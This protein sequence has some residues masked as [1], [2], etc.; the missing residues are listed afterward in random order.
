MDR[1]IAMKCVMVVI[2]GLWHQ[3]SNNFLPLTLYLLGF[4]KYS[5]INIHYFHCQKKCFSFREDYCIIFK[6]QP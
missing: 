4:S 3:A 2:S 1:K 6:E 5:M